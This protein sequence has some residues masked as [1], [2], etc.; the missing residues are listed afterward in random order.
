MPTGHG[1]TRTSANAPD[2][3]GL[4]VNE[5]LLRDCHGLYIDKTSP[6][7]G[8]YF[9][10]LNDEEQKYFSVKCIMCQKSENICAPINTFTPS[11]MMNH[12][13]WKFYFLWAKDFMVK[14]R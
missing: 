7:R 10:F 13:D 1:K 4:S 12:T 11:T 5:K 3:T 2:N 14:S 8:L 9:I 6:E